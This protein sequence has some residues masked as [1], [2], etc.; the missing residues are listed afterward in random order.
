MIASLPNARLGDGL[1]MTRAFLGLA[2][3]HNQ[4]Q[5]RSPSSGQ[6]Q[7]SVASLRLCCLVGFETGA[8]LGP[9]RGASSR[10]LS[11]WHSAMSRRVRARGGAGIIRDE[12]AQRLEVRS[13][14]VTIPG[15]AADAPVQLCA[16]AL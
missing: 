1:L 10:V 13:D 6:P 9:Y 3:S 11:R 8:S 15:Q 16:L 4:L 2:P 7:V 5:G 12:I 14:G